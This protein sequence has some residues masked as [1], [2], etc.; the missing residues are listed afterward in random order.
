MHQKD[1]NP[2]HEVIRGSYRTGTRIFE[3]TRQGRTLDGANKRSKRRFRSRKDAELKEAAQLRAEFSKLFIGTITTLCCY[4]MLVTFLR[5]VRHVDIT[6]LALAT[7]LV[8]LGIFGILG[9]SIGVVSPPAPAPFE[10]LRPYL[11]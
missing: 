10:H 11:E 2:G 4:A 1:L 9:T 3:L 8:N 7:H 5:E 6:P